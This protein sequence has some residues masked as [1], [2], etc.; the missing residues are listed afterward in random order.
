MSNVQEEKRA[1]SLVFTAVIT[2]NIM[3]IG[4][5][6]ALDNDFLV[7][8]FSSFNLLIGL[9]I[10]QKSKEHEQEQKSEG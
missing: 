5:S 10:G 2:A 7:M 4:I 1:L 9:E 6:L 3:A 8:V